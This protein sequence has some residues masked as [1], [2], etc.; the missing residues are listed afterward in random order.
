MRAQV[1]ISC[2][3]SERPAHCLCVPVAIVQ[4][5]FSAQLSGHLSHQH[6]REM[7]H[8]P[9]SSR[10]LVGPS[11]AAASD[12][13]T[14]L[15]FDIDD[16]KNTVLRLRGDP[17]LCYSVHTINHNTK[18]TVHGRD[19]LLATIEIKTL[20]PDQ[21]T[22]PGVSPMNLSHWLKSPMLSIL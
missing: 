14:I 13:N 19:L 18:T 12:G 4:H 7:D 10:T 8:P 5:G 20:R 6:S 3:T 21:I 11:V 9:D 1:A 22:F 17:R 2:I 16:M 15:L